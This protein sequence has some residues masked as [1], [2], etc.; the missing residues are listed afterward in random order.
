MKCKEAYLRICDNLDADPDSEK[1]RE[2]LKHLETC[3]DCAAL[4]DS[5]KKTVLLYKS[6]PTPRVPTATHKRLVR[7]INAAWESPRRRLS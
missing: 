3:A 7:A 2:V 6:T 1:C 5:V 4:L